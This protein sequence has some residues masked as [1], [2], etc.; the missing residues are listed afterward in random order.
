M[1]EDAFG[2]EVTTDSDE[3]A[4]AW[5]AAI[6]DF[7]ESRLSASAHV[8]TALEADP[9]FVP[10]LC[11][12]GYFLMQLSTVQTAGKAAGVLKEAKAHAKGATAREQMHVAAL[13]HW[14]QGRV[15]KACDVWEEILIDAPRDLLALRLHHF[16]S[17]WQGRKAA[18]P[19]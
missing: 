4:A 9:H 1:A 10:A 2:L 7:L 3:A 16:L 11:F 19:G 5:S 15:G 6:V 18:F 12:R 14:T 17:F 13:E 8:K